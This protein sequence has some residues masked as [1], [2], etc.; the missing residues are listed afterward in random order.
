MFFKLKFNISSY[1]EVFL[2]YALNYCENCVTKKINISAYSTPQ[3]MSKAPI[4]L[5]SRPMSE[6]LVQGEDVEKLTD[7]ELKQ[8]V[9]LITGKIT[10]EMGEEQV[11]RLH[12]EL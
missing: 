8:A 4:V 5:P 12:H 11:G 6:E 3:V 9:E 7:D 1:S 2:T 10:L